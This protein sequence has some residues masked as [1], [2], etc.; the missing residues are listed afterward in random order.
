M[1]KRKPD[2]EAAGDTQQADAEEQA[3]AA[4]EAEEGAGEEVA[5]PPSYVQRSATRHV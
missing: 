1:A 4:S 5:P 2:P 3:S